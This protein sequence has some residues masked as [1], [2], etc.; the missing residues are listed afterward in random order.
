MNGEK[1]FITQLSF[2]LD[3][4]KK[5]VQN[6]ETA[7]EIF[8]QGWVII[9]MF[10]SKG[11]SARHSLTFLPWRTGATCLRKAADCGVARSGLVMSWACLADVLPKKPFLSA[12]I[13]SVCLCTR[14]FDC[15]EKLWALFLQVSISCFEGE[16]S[17]NSKGR[18][19]KSHP[20]FAPQSVGYAGRCL[21]SSVCM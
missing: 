3:C 8:W 11:R 6:C 17:I 2:S 12:F 4:A 18:C 10:Q 14:C 9:Y 19:P 5:K 7:F 15:P 1:Q 16:G 20:W 13:L 21:S